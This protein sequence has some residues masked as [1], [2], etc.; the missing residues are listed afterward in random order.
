M[1]LHA[2]SLKESPEWEART[3]CGR[4]ISHFSWSDGVEPSQVTTYLG[5]VNLRYVP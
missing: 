5:D 4:L 2:Y 3:A 1:K